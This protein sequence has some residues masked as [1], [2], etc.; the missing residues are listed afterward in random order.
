MLKIVINA[1]NVFQRF[2]YY[3]HF[4]I[5]QYLHC[6]KKSTLTHVDNYVSKH[7]GSRKSYKQRSEVRTGKCERT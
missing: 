7:T 2:Y 6:D 3:K 5:S 1:K 4:L